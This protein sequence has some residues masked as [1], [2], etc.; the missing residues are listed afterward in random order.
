MPPGADQHERHD[1]QNGRHELH[2]ARRAHAPRIHPGEEPHGAHRDDSGRC[3]MA[4]NGR[5][6][7][8]EI[9]H[10]RHGEG[11]V[12]APHRDPV[13][14]R[15]QE[16]GKIAI[17]LPR[18]R[19]GPAGG[20]IEAGQSR[21]DQREKDWYARAVESSHPPRPMPPKGASEAG[22]RKT[23]DPIMIMTR[24]TAVQ[25]PSVRGVIGCGSD[26]VDTSAQ[27]TSVRGPG[28]A[29]GRWDGP[30]RQAV[31]SSEAYPW[32]PRCR[33]RAGRSCSRRR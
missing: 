24:A 28:R 29:R 26:A 10:E 21:E 23:P 9:P 12:R 27:H 22:S 13:A 18:E 32:V 1:L 2:P 33:S 25:N 19:V 31:I 6:E 16:A 11:R 5:H 20:R 15:N 8:V 3:G 30:R 7:W 4:D 14:P 17:G